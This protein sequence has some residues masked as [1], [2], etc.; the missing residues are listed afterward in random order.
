[1]DIEEIAWKGV[2]YI[3]LAQDV[4]KWL[5][6]VNIVMNIIV[7]ISSIVLFVLPFLEEE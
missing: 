1:M 3:S 6:T 7:C 5:G 2:G 4:D